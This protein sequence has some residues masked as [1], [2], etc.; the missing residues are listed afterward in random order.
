[1]DHGTIL[2]WFALFSEAT[3]M[4]SFGGGLEISL[5]HLCRDSK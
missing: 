2:S 5:E 1:M 3:N 4:G